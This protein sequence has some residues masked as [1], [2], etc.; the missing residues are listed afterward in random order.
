M[1]VNPASEFLSSL[2]AF[3]LAEELEF[4]TFG[5]LSC[6]STAAAL[7]FPKND[8]CTTVFFSC[9]PGSLTLT[10][11]LAINR[12]TNFQRGVLAKPP[13]MTLLLPISPLFESDVTNFN[14]S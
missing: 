7:W 1:Q 13:L 5:V 11:V 8:P 9:K 14:W 3:E 10:K 12:P 4:V 2:A 6:M